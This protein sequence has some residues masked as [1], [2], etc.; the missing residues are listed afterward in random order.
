MKEKA[1][2]DQGFCSKTLMQCIEMNVCCTSLPVKK[3]TPT[4]PPPPSSP[5]SPPPPTNDH[6]PE[7]VE[8]SELGED[9]D[10]RDVTSTLT[11]LANKKHSPGLDDHCN[12]LKKQQQWG[13]GSSW[14]TMNLNRDLDG[15]ELT[16]EQKAAKNQVP[17]VILKIRFKRFDLCKKFT[18]RNS[19]G[20]PY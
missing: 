4:S 16:L 17:G 5:T 15:M 7:K 12:R 13:K 14:L 8:N 6:D 11:R 2:P 3:T 18:F 20:S 1:Q 10:Q 19:G 9:W